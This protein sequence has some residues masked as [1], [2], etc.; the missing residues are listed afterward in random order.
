MLS[1]SKSDIS[2]HPLG[3]HKVNKRESE[4]E[5]RRITVAI[6]FLFQPKC[7]QS[8]QRRL[9][10]SNFQCGVA[11]CRNKVILA[12]YYGLVIQPRSRMLSQSVKTTSVFMF[13]VTK[14]RECLYFTAVPKSK[15]E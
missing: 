12:F 2:I 13:H 14:L 15:K 3:K 5:S 1:H 11:N 8:W 6:C 4:D 9:N 10:L 7:K